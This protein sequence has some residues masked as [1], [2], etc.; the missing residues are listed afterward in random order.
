M[1]IEDFR[2]LYRATIQDASHGKLILLDAPTG[3][4]KSYTVTQFLCERA[5]Q[6]ANFK[7]FFVS[8]QKKNLPIDDFINCWNQPTSN[9]SA[10]ANRKIAILR[11]LSDTVDRLLA[12][13][14]NQHIPNLLASDSAFTEAL[15]NLK[16][17]RKLYRLAV[18]LNSNLD[19]SKIIRTAEYQIRKVITQ[20][21]CQEANI[22][23]GAN[24]IDQETQ[25]QIRQYLIKNETPLSVWLSDVYPTIN[26][27]SYQIYILSTDKWI[28]SYQDFF[29][30]GGVS[31]LFS[32]IIKD[33]LV[34]FDEY[35]TT[36]QRLWNKAIDE[37]LKVQVDLL[38][39]FNALYSGLSQVEAHAPG[40]LR[41]LLMSNQELANLL[42]GANELATDF[43]LDFLYK[44][45]G[46]STVSNY[47]IH[48]P[49]DTIISASRAWNSDFNAK[50][51]IVEVS[52]TGQDELH[53][54]WML[55]RLSG[56][57]RRVNRFIFMIAK[58]YMDQRN[59][60]GRFG[61]RVI[62]L[63]DSVR[64]IY[65]AFG[66]ETN[67]I[68]V[69]LQLATSDN[70]K[71]KKPRHAKQVLNQHREFQ[72]R[73]MDLFWFN[74][75]DQH[76]FQTEINAAFFSITPEHYL[77]SLL[78]RCH[79]WGLSATAMFPTVIDNYDHAYI[80]EKIGDYLIDGRTLLTDHTIAQF[81]FTRRYQERNIEVEADIVGLSTSIEATLKALVSSDLTIDWKAIRQL[82]DQ[83]QR[84][85]KEISQSEVSNSK[86]QQAYFKE[87]YLAL[88]ESF[89]RFML[90]PTA[91]LFVGL[92]AK[93]PDNSREMSQEL[94]K[95][96]FTTLR[97]A[98]ADPNQAVELQIVA[99]SK[100]QNGERV[101]DQLKRILDFSHDS[102]RRVYLLSAYLTIGVGQNLQHLL[103]GVD[104]KDTVS[105]ANGDE[106][107]QDQRRFTKDA[108][109][110]YLG[111]VTNILTN[112]KTS[113]LNA[114]MM[115]YLTELEYLL[116]ANELGHEDVRQL[117]K[118][119]AIQKPDFRRRKALPSVVASY[120]RTIVQALGRMNRTLNKSKHPLVLA[121]P[122]VVNSISDMGMD[123]KR[124]GPEFRALL[125][126]T[127]QDN[128][129]IANN[130]QLV[131]NQKN[132]LTAYCARDIRQ[133]VGY[134][135]KVPERA[136]EYTE[137][138]EFLLRNPTLSKQKMLDNQDAAGRC[139]Q[140]LPNP[141]RK[142]AY[143][144]KALNVKNGEYTFSKQDA[145][146]VTVSSETARLDSMLK[147]P[148]MRQYFIKNGYAT[149]WKAN[150]YIL[151]PVQFV[152]LYTGILGEVAGKYI[153]EDLF[154]IKLAPFTTLANHEL[155]D[156][157]TT[158]HVAV[159]YKNWDINHSED[160]AKPRRHVHDK[161]TTLHEHTE[162][163]WRSLVVNVVGQAQDRNV[164]RI[165]D[166]GMEIA[167]LIDTD[168]NVTLSKA[169]KMMIGEFLIGKTTS[170]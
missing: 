150:D 128:A 42:R 8:D 33:A 149:E 50:A 37:A 46:T 38:P 19:H 24:G 100:D 49:L 27:P 23:C 14:D 58:R 155:F 139:F 74:D 103:S 88:F 102:N 90:R 108:D 148:G 117:F 66:L 125:A 41:A 170:N 154:S 153:L 138:R 130:Q 16:S 61:T 47:V 113:Q 91:S 104:Q 97:T 29:K 34:V 20:I 13:W 28:R 65:H 162:A 169:D 1:L 25:K 116:D 111:A 18:G 98:L 94:I 31:F 165:D 166:W 73:G 12:D 142:V 145:N 168:G 15:Q 78:Q 10:S 96:V 127:D 107:V 122:D 56:F 163:S 26:L 123:K 156:A 121:H 69:L 68:E 64:S 152:N 52:R 144:V 131:I 82:D 109:G 136:K 167:S 92:Q 40:N 11:S 22:K 63:A 99:T 133:L 124:F 129:G 55:W 137:I 57:I 135:D 160:S 17:Q 146:L 110:M 36:K 118:A 164:E 71:L 59:A 114:E 60:S 151:N 93:L 30:P 105:I 72:K 86:H 115:R 67:Q 140:Y 84:T 132:N 7:A 89:I 44:V 80:R 158:T 87:R 21:L 32:P 2:K 62:S 101:E 83:L 6:D 3:S 157:K 4:G 120:T 9:A 75:S 134:L 119:I 95:H 141:N 43:R 51:K 54:N 147:Y 5:Q 39:L 126:L 85:V 70:Q 53:F 143:T 112:L 76:D 77:L 35:D 106:P 81:D 48:T 45:I 79:V 159:D 161:L